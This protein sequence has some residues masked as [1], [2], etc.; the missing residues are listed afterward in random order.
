MV[1]TFGFC[2]L[3]TLHLE[4][5]KCEARL[6]GISTETMLLL[7]I[8]LSAAA[9]CLAIHRDELLREIW[10]KILEVGGNALA[11]LCRIEQ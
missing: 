10:M 3:F 1:A 2:E 11:K 6:R 7:K 8:V 4:D 9:D 5:V